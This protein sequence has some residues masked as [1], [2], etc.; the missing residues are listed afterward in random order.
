MQ[1]P[2]IKR[3]RI[4]QAV[5]AIVLAGAL[6]SLCRGQSEPGDEQAREK[7]IA[8]LISQLG[9]D[10]FVIRERA[11]QALADLGLDALDALAKAQYDDDVEIAVRARRILLSIQVRWVVDGDPSSARRVLQHYGQLPAAQRVTAIERLE[12]LPA[13]RGLPPL[14]RIARYD[15]SPRV[16]RFA[17]LAFL[18]SPCPPLER[19]ERVVR[20]V[21]RTLG[22]SRRVAVE[23]IHVALRLWEHPEQSV[24]A[25]AEIVE[26]EL[27]TFLLHP[28]RNGP[29][30]LRA[31]LL[32]HVDVLLEHGRCDQAHQ[33]ARRV[34][35]LL[36]DDSAQLIET[37]D[38]LLEHDWPDLMEALYARFRDSFHQDTTLLFRLAEARRRNG[39]DVKALQAARAA[40]AQVGPTAGPRGVWLLGISLQNDGFFHWAEYAYRELTDAEKPDWKENAMVFLSLAEMLHDLQRDDEA[41]Q[42]LQKLVNASRQ[43]P[44]KTAIE[45]EIR[46]PIDRLA[47]RAAYFQAC[48]FARSGD[49]DAEREALQRSLALAPL[50]ADS[51]ILLYRM[52]ADDPGELLEAR[53]KIA[54][55]VA[56]YRQRIEQ[57]KKSIREARSRLERLQMEFD[58]AQQ[59]NQVAWL[60]ANTDGDRQFALQCAKQAQRFYPDSAGIR[61]TLARCYFAIGDVDRAIQEQRQALEQEPH[62]PPLRAQL[63]MFL[64]HQRQAQ[65]TAD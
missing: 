61:D 31:L 12:G 46:Q 43:R 16:A 39:D 59:Y 48:H 51:L 42:T 7:K 65:P 49:R 62:S 8:T 19:R 5:G 53:R 11:S 45:R 27:S 30:V 10:E 6:G 9:S 29:D 35:P 23:W 36:P 3:R 15:P 17:A 34:L 55:A 64:K 2:G 1:L 38:W 14:A 18:R 47:A 60:I 52:A 37:A 40:L 26:R 41:A 50:D 21:E 44:L 24:A 32:G 28:E 33:T 22:N 56:Q 54:E 63:E 25:W 58:I 13:G 4:A 20:D 57:S